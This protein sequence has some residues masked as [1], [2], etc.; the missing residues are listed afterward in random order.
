MM[1]AIPP[2]TA[3]PAKCDLQIALR[4]VLTYPNCPL[5]IVSVVGQAVAADGKVLTPV[6]FQEWEVPFG[7]WWRSFADKKLQQ[8]GGLQLSPLSLTG[9]LRA[10]GTS[11]MWFRTDR[12]G[13]QPRQCNLFS[14]PIYNFANWEF[15][16]R[17]S[18]L[19]APVSN[20]G[21]DGWMAIKDFDYGGIPTTTLAPGATLP[22]FRSSV[23]VASCD[24]LDFTGER[25]C[26]KAYTYNLT[27]TFDNGLVLYD[28]RVPMTK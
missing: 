15:S 17:A 13:M 16:L 11:E 14:P 9:S 6:H 8:V 3:G 4:A 20:V 7:C 22:A 27:I 10:I 23:E 12:S 2:T 24:T 21:R 18:P 26:K 25:W 19:S 28:V 1:T 5:K